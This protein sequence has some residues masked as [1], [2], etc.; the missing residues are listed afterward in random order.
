MAKF[1]IC[2][3]ISGE[4]DVEYAEFSM[5]QGLML[6]DSSS[7]ASSVAG[8]AALSPTSLVGNLEDKFKLMSL[9][10]GSGNRNLNSS[11]VKG[12]Q[13]TYLD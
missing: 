12:K 3:L 13:R 8:A 1:F 11:S 10:D 2:F 6:R 4:N 5:A 9:F 7:T